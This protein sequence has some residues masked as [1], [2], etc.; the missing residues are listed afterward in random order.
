MPDESLSTHSKQGNLHHGKQIA[1]MAQD[2]IVLKCKSRFK[3]RIML[4]QRDL[5]AA[6]IGDTLKAIADIRKTMQ[7]RHTEVNV[8]WIYRDNW[9]GGTS[10][11]DTVDYLST[12]LDDF[13][14]LSRKRWKMNIL[15]FL[16]TVGIS[17]S[18]ISVY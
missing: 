4:L 7:D 11:N 16:I 1:I 3:L 9:S 14:C 10:N 13:Y 6:V 5:R 8:A 15:R 17:A 2:L 12:N 18:C